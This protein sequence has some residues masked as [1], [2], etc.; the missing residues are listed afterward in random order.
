MEGFGGDGN[1]D[2]SGARHFGPK[3]PCPAFDAVFGDVCNNDAPEVHCYKV[4]ILPGS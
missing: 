2:I 4:I 1:G 3:R